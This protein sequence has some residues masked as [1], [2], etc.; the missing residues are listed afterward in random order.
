MNKK[1]F[2]LVALLVI[3]GTV[4]ILLEFNESKGIV[5]I[6]PNPGEDVGMKFTLSGSAPTSWLMDGRLGFD[7]NTDNSGQILGSILETNRDYSLLEFWNV[8][9]KKFVSTVDTSGMTEETRTCYGKAVLTVH[10][11]IDENLKQSVEVN[12]N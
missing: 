9:R 6:S 4:F 1:A 3:V 5:I 8:G 2:S 12:C 10:S 7:I 11:L